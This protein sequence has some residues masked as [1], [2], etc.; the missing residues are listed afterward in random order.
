M[1]PTLE[2]KEHAQE[3]LDYI[4]ANPDQHDQNNFWTGTKGQTKNVCD[5]AMCVA[6]TSVY[7]KEGVEGMWKASDKDD[8]DSV[9]FYQK[10]GDNLGLSE[11]ERYKL[12]YCF[13]N[14]YA[15]DMLRAVAAGDEDKFH[16]IRE[17]YNLHAYR[18]EDDDF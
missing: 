9:S 15:V 5:T 13:N 8:Y 3:I 1:Q 11:D 2:H 7:L 12:F 4:M 18:S 10:A 6:G 17:A 14:E 16:A